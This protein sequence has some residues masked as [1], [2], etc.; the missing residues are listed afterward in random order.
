[1]KFEERLNTALNKLLNE[2]PMSYHTRSKLHPPTPRE[3]TGQVAKGPAQS[4]NE[5]TKG[6]YKGN[7]A[8]RKRKIRHNATTDNIE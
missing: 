7:Y 6:A 4:T 5:P 1:M 8:R 3:E 2:K